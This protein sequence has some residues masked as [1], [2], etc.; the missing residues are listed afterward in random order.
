MFLFCVR[1]RSVVPLLPHRPTIGTSAVSLSGDFRDRGEGKVFFL[2]STGNFLDRS[3]L[4]KNKKILV[5]TKLEM[6]TI[7]L[8]R[9]NNKK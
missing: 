6:K 2:E 7:L 5:L 4:L 9:N 8:V 1:A 3:G